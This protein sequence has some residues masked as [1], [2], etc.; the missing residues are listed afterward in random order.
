LEI[1]SVF[2]GLGKGLDVGGVEELGED[3][4]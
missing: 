3:K 2:G 4:R 1:R